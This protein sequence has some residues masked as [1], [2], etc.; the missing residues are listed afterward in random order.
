MNKDKNQLNKPTPYDVGRYGGFS[1]KPGHSGGS[2]ERTPYDLNSAKSGSRSH[3]TR[4]P[5]SK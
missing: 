3:P 1:G 5:N 2:G 4:N